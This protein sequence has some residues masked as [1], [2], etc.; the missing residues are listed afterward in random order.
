[1]YIYRRQTM[2]CFFPPSSLYR[3]Y[4]D[5]QDNYKTQ[6]LLMSTFKKQQY[7]NHPSLFS[8]QLFWRYK[9]LLN[10]YV[11]ERFF[12]FLLSIIWLWS[13]GQHVLRPSKPSR[14]ND[15]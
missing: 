15:T 11:I 8:L 13:N 1:M 6:N 9:Q 10:K 7:Y 5:L 2:F 12:F 4:V 3:R 14:W